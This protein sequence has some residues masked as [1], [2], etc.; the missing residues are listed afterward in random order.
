MMRAMMSRRAA[1]AAAMLLGTTA[2]VPPPPAAAQTSTAPAY[3]QL[4]MFASLLNQVRAN[5][6]DSVEFGAL[7]RA[8]IRGMLRSLDPHSNYVSR[9]EFE[10]RA[11]YERGL[12]AGVGMAI[13]D[14]DGMATVLTVAQNGPAARAG[15][16]PGDRV[17]AVG[18]SVVAGIGARELELRL[19]GEKGTEVRVALERGPR[20]EPDSF[21]VRLKRQVIEAHVVADARMADATTGYVRL[22][23]FTPLAPRELSDSIKKLTG[24]GA[25]QLILDL[26]GNGGGDVDAMTQIAGLFLGGNV[27][28]FH[29]QGRKPSGR[30][31]AVT[32]ETGPFAG[33]PLVILINEGT[34][35]ASEILTGSLQDHDRA[36]VIGRR[37]FGKA[38]MQRA[39]PLANGDVVWLS[40]ARVLMPSGRVIQRRYAGLAFEQYEALAGTTGAA[41]DTAGVYHTDHGRIVRGG[42][43]IHPDIERRVGDL[44]AWF[45]VA[46][47]SGWIALVAD[48]VAQTLPSGDKA[49]AA[50]LAAPERWD[51]DVAAPFLGRVQAH[52]GI[53]TLPDAA[54]RERITRFLAARV[55]ETRWGG[56]A[57]LEFWLRNDPDVRLAL[58]SF[59]RIA[60]LLAAN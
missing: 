48:S 3:E 32:K 12:L 50:W 40:T 8:S 56:S 20:L 58:D 28:V 60:S 27:E 4:Q 10:L 52:L 11:R 45:S 9:Q 13:E 41:A 42:G 37:S 39:L 2:L 55:V 16:Q 34:A 46:A 14:A 18:D 35:S 24:R 25:R 31:K 49:Q 19:L 30:D 47:D 29:T 38:L 7:V 17:R 59:P 26:R 57:A 33:L 43:G 23:Q 51:H 1:V 53:H 21:A 36:L 22:A 15:I 6:V 44:P 5:Y 54:T